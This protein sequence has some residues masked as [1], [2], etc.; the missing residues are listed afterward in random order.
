MP[1]TGTRFRTSPMAAANACSLPE[2]NRCDPLAELASS[3]CKT[4]HFTIP[5]VAS[6]ICISNHPLGQSPFSSPPD[7]S[8]ASVEML[9]ETPI[10]STQ[11]GRLLAKFTGLHFSRALHPGHIVLRA[12]RRSARSPG[13]HQD[14]DDTVPLRRIFQ[15]FIPASLNYKT[16]AIG[17]PP[18]HSVPPFRSLQLVRDPRLIHD[19]ALLVRSLAF[20]CRRRPIGKK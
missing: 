2:R 13:R 3:L 12:V 8:T 15:F 16:Q 14:S 9:W 18:P 10:L 19:R 1:G 6:T 11:N 5:F 7:F 17:N 20:S 4:E